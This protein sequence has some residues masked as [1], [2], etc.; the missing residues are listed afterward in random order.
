LG[1]DTNLTALFN[2]VCPAGNG[3]RMENAEGL[4]NSENQTFQDAWWS[5]KFVGDEFVYYPVDK[6]KIPEA[7]F[8]EPT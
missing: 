7:D 2:H 4:Y 8:R 6:I 3:N 1:G 5:D